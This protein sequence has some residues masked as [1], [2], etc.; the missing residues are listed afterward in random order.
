M[1]PSGRNQWQP[2]ANEQ[3]P[4]TPETSQVASPLVVYESVEVVFRGGRGARAVG[5]RGA[6]AAG[7]GDS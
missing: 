4:K 1:E 3:A 2:V 6:T 7:P 5:E